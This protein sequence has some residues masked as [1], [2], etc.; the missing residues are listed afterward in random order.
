MEQLQ[1]NKNFE[2]QKDVITNPFIKI[3]LRI[4]NF[5]LYEWINFIGMF[6]FW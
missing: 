3:F 4:K 6:I 2:E 1:S 5:K